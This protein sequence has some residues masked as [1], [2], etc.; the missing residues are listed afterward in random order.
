MVCWKLPIESTM[1]DSLEL[2]RC[3]MLSWSTID[4]KL[5]VGDDHVE[6]FDGALLVHGHDALVE[7]GLGHLQVVARDGEGARFCGDARR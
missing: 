2:T 7:H 6:Q 1:V 3:S 4:E 5:L